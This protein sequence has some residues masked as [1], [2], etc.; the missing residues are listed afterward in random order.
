MCLIWS[1]YV[2]YD[3]EMQ[4]KAKLYVTKYFCN[5]NATKFGE[6]T[7]FAPISNDPIG[8]SLIFQCYMSCL[9]KFISIQAIFIQAI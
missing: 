1:I 3:N 6:D 4:F 8:P 2:K 7:Q 9:W 5:T